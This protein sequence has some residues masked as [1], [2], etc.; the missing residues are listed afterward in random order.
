MIRLLVT[1]Q[2]DVIRDRKPRGHLDSVGALTRCVVVPSRG[3]NSEF[4]LI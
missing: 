1:R 4:S 2:G 3:K